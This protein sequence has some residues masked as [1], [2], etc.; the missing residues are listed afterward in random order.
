MIQLR[1]VSPPSLTAA[2]RAV[3]ESQ[4]GVANL[5][6]LPGSVIRPPG[7]LILCEVADEVAS[8]VLQSLSHFGLEEHG[9]ITMNRIDYA[10]S[11][12]ARE[13]EAEAPGSAAN[14]VVWEAVEM[15]TSESGSLTA[16]FV[17]FIVIASLIAAAGLLSDSLILIIGAMVVSPEFGPLAGVS[18]ALNQARWPL[19]LRSAL[20]LCIGFGAAV[21]VA[22]IAGLILKPTD[23]AP[24]VLHG[25]GS[26]ATVFISTPG[27][28]S[29]LVAIC[30]AVAGILS[31]VTSKSGALVG[32][33]IS[34]TTLPAATNMGLAVAYADG[35][36][37][38]G[39][40]ANL[41]LNLASIVAAGAITLRVLL[42]ASQRNF[43][44]F[45]RAASLLGSP[46][47]GSPPSSG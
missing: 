34:V 13:A 9:G 16:S 6:L 35:G 47:G 11:R 19:A 39:S 28:W 30:A 18:I 10:L 8:Y 42:W 36:E 32:V 27:T 41:G 20:A 7:D 25:Q 1:I 33:L 12:S 23:V 17:A 43:A 14:A 5:A 29:V 31:F 44:R 24:D 21:L 3:L 45:R 37:F 22:L 15:L 4:A 46:R 2:V 38:W 26:Q 40:A